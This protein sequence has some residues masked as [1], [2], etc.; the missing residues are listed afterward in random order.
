MGAKKK[1]PNKP[2]SFQQPPPKT[3][4]QKITP[5]PPQ[6]KEKDKSHAGFAS[7]K[8]P[9]KALNNIKCSGVLRIK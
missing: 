3:P 7:L 6:K 8:N 9:R 2:Q 5:P 4:D 1:T